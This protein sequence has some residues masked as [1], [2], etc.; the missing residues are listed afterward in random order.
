MI[1]LKLQSG[2]LLFFQIY[3][4]VSCSAISDGSGLIFFPFRTLT[5]LFL[6]TPQM[7]SSELPDSGPG[8]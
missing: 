1:S 8:F 2:R 4:A 7:T 6:P 3:L 5:L